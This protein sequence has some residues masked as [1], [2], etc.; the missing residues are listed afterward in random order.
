MTEKLIGLDL[1]IGASESV[2]IDEFKKLGQV[3]IVDIKQGD[4]VADVTGQKGKFAF[5]I[6]GADCTYTVGADTVMKLVKATGSKTPV[7]TSAIAKKLTS[8]KHFSKL[9][10]ANTRQ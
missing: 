9:R 4:F 5:I 1:S 10:Q 7:M 6:Q 2:V 3:Q 8:S